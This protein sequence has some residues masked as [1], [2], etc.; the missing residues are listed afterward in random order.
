LASQF[1]ISVL[2]D[3]IRISGVDRSG[4]GAAVRDLD[5]DS[6]DESRGQALFYASLCLAA[7]VIWRHRSTFPANPRQRSTVYSE[8][9]IGKIAILGAG[10]WGTALASLWSK[11]ARQIVLWGHN[12]D[13][14][15][16]IQK[17]RENV[18]YL[19]GLRL[20]DS[21]HVTSELGDC[22]RVDL[23]VFVTPS[24]ALRHIATA[25]RKLTDSTLPVLLTCT[26]GIE[27]PERCG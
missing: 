12:P 2:H 22:A 19:P 7:F 6:A 24:T 11:N 8:V 10:A 4:Y 16:D 26:K 9:K 3:A 5:H 15:A 21:V 25:L 23:V 1:D 18:H 20:P 27:P 17:A 13:R 14:L